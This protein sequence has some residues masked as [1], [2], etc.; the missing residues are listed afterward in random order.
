MGW[1]LGLVVKRSITNKEVMRSIHVA[2]GHLPRNNVV[3]SDYSRRVRKLSRQ[4][5]RYIYRKKRPHR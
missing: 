1:P 4:S 5:Y 3:R 2:T